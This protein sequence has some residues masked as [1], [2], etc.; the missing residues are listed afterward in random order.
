MEMIAFSLWFVSVIGQLL[1]K[2][3]DHFFVFRN[4][5]NNEKIFFGFCSKL[6][7]LVDKLMIEFLV[8]VAQ[9]AM[10]AVYLVDF[11]FEFESEIDFLAKG[12]LGRIVL[13]H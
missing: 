13:I 4:T 3:D 9:F 8:F 5:V 7:G 2:I 12:L 10:K 1:S 6:L 11:S